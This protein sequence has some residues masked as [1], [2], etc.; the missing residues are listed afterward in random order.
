MLEA[1][2]IS[3]G[4]AGLTMFDAT[5]NIE[6]NLLEMS[7]YI[8]NVNTGEVTY[9]VRDSVYNGIEIKKNQFMGIVNGKIVTSN[10]TKLE[11]CEIILKE[12]IDD[13]TEIVTIMHGSDVSDKEA[14]ELTDYIDN[15]FSV[16]IEVIDGGQDIYSYI[17]TV[18]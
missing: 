18:E 4:Y 3:Q 8:K 2:T 6:E 13:R 14:N 5:Q 15:N 11:A 16:E 1:K 12:M 17:I 9:A 7:E 10:E